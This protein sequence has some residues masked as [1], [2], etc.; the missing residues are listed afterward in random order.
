[1][2]NQVYTVLGTLQMADLSSQ[3]KQLPRRRERGRSCIMLQLWVLL[4][5]QILEE[6]T[7]QIV[8]RDFSCLSGEAQ[9]ITF[10]HLFK[11]HRAKCVK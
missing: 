6:K 5:T 2:G 11:I 10:I 3:E 1:M 4:V 7:S 9:L 8:L